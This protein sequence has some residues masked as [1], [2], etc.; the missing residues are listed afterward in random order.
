MLMTRKCRSS[1]QSTMAYTLRGI[2]RTRLPCGVLPTQWPQQQ[3]QN[4]P[5]FLFSC[6]LSFL[7]FSFSHVP[8]P[9]TSPCQSFKLGATKVLWILGLAIKGPHTHHRVGWGDP[10]AAGVMTPGLRCLYVTLGATSL[11]DSLALDKSL[12]HPH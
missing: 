3:Q 8:V 5:A 12:S 4:H 7:L 2:K 6:Y 10:H 1:Q 9:A 11:Y